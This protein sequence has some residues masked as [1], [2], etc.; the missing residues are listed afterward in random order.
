MIVVLLA[1]LLQEPWEFR[2]DTAVPESELRLEAI[3]AIDLADAVKLDRRQCAAA[4]ALAT[5]AGRKRAAFLEGAS[6]V[7]K[8]LAAALEALEAAL[9]RC[10]HADEARR[11]A[12]DVQ[13]KLAA[14][15]SDHQA[16]LKELERR[17]GALMT[18]LQ[19]RAAVAHRSQLA[20]RPKP[21]ARPAEEIDE[22]LEG[23]R[24]LPDA[25][26]ARIIEPLLDLVFAEHE[27]WRDLGEE[28]RRSERARIRKL[29]ERARAMGGLEFEIAKADIAAEVA[30]PRP[31]G[32][33]KPSTLT[34]AGRILLNPRA[35]AILKA[36]A[37]VAPC[38]VCRKE[39]RREKLSGKKPE[40]DEFAEW[41]ELDGTQRDAALAAIGRAQAELLDTLSG[42]DAKD[43]VPLIEMFRLGIDGE[44]DFGEVMGGT[45]P[46]TRQT[47]FQRAMTIK[48]RLDGELRKVLSAK[49]FTRYSSAD[50]DVFGI[51]VG[52]LRPY[53]K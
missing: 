20:A 5:E 36:R 44:G 49:Q 27:P 10:G 48:G 33:A 46:G 4:A 11:K 29:L 24:N 39:P 51:K 14:I 52:D 42:K 47:Y 40:F 7:R 22:H 1:A 12:A 35:A 53:A 26:F 45:I 2:D 41:M 3:S 16:A 28:D 30:E 15:E 32:P 9:A 38:D 13:A 21:A 43:R 50:L 19:R 23:L 18:P 25:V 8:E 6:S 17:L 31:Q 37:D 34:P